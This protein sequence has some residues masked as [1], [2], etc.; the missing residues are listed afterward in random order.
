M[1]TSVALEIFCNF[2]IISYK[3]LHLKVQFLSRYTTSIYKTLIY[4]FFHYSTLQDQ[5]I[6]YLN[7]SR[8]HKDIQLQNHTII[9]IPSFIILPFILNCFVLCVK[10]IL[11]TLKSYFT[12]VSSKTKL[13]LHYIA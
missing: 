11:Q 6:V 4:I 12:I 13:K 7:P 1:D 2:G 3:S 5:N 10:H 9:F 8:I